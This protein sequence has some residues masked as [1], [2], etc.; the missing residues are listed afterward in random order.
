M[1]AVK[2]ENRT[3]MWTIRASSVRKPRFRTPRARPGYPVR[4]QSVPE[5][6]PP[7]Q[8]SVLSINRPRKYTHIEC[9]NARREVREKSNLSMLLITLSCSPIAL[10]KCKSSFP[11]S[12]SWSDSTTFPSGSL[13]RSIR[14]QA[15]TFRQ[16]WWLEAPIWA[17]IFHNSGFTPIIR[18]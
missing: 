13:G 15:Y 10:T 7:L 16:C 1:K 3:T 4:S 2:L 17:Y 11:K 5:W 8:E 12:V 18:N 9:I 6:E 14:K